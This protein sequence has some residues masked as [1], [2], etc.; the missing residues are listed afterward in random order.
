M[1]GLLRVRGFTQDDA[2]IFCTPEQIEGE[3]E[4]C[5]DFA[6]AVLR[7]FGFEKIPRRTLHLGSERQKVHRQRRQVG[8]RRRLAHPR[9]RSQADPLPHH[10]RRSRLLR[11]QDRHQASR[12]A[13]PTLAALHRAIR[14]EPPRPLRPR[15]HRRGRRTAPARHG[16]PARSSAPSSVS[17]ACSSST[18]PAPSPCG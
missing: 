18:T 10:S 6:E 12:R 16:S 2:H 4:A 7:T 1:H 8:E 15:V 17:S 11:P 9:A 13:R 14:L 3:V 5:I